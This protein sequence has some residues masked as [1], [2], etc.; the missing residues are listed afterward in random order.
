MSAELGR[1]PRQIILYY[2]VVS[3]WRRKQSSA[4]LS[5]CEFSLLSGKIQGISH[6]FGLQRE[7]RRPKLTL[8]Q[9]VAGKFP[10]QWNREFFKGYQGKHLEEQGFSFAEQ[11]TIECPKSWMS[12]GVWVDENARVPLCY[13]RG[14]E[15]ACDCSDTDRLCCQHHRR[16]LHLKIH[17]KRIRLHGIDAPR[18]FSTDFLCAWNVRFSGFSPIRRIRNTIRLG[19]AFGTSNYAFIY[20]AILVT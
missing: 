3:S 15:P 16:Q 2:Q 18:E 4:N 20:F 7:K 5:Q 14:A 19:R 10:M 8:Q 12:Q 6:E 9:W 13:G 1:R 17:G 11:A